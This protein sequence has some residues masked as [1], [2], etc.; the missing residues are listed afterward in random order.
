MKNKRYGVVL[1]LLLAAIIVMALTA[2]G[3]SSPLVGK[4]QFTEGPGYLEFF[5][6]GKFEM[7]AGSEQVTGKYKESGGNQVTLTPDSQYIEESDEY[8]PVTLEYSFSGDELI[9]D[10]GWS[11]I[12]FTR[13]D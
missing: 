12:S 7:Q 13:V 1:I 2:C 8:E 6:N 11:P 9:L 5:S 3:S 10:D 4:W